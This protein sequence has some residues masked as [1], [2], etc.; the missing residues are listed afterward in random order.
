[1][2]SALSKFENGW[3]AAHPDYFFVVTSIEAVDADG[4]PD[5]QIGVFSDVDANGQPTTAIQT[6]PEHTVANSQGLIY[7]T[8]VATDHNQVLRVMFRLVSSTATKQCTLLIERYTACL[9]I[10]ALKDNKG[11]TVFSPPV[12]S[13][14]IHYDR[15]SQRFQL[16]V[17]GAYVRDQ[18]TYLID[19]DDF[20]PLHDS[21]RFQGACANRDGLPN[22][23]TLPWRE[24]WYSAPTATFPHAL[25]GSFPAY[26]VR[27]N[28]LVD[29][30][31][32]QCD[33]VHFN[34]TYSFTDFTHCPTRHT[35][36]YAVAVTNENGQIFYRGKV[37]VNVLVPIDLTQEQWGYSK[38]R[39][40]YP[41][42]FGFKQRISAL[43]G[44]PTQ[45]DLRVF[46][47]SASTDPV[48]GIMTLVVET[49]YARLE[50]LKNPSVSPAGEIVL[51][52]GSDP[53][54]GT[55]SVVLCIQEWTY[56]SPASWTDANNHDYQFSWQAVYDSH[57]MGVRITIQQKLEEIQSETG[58]MIGDLQLRIFH[59]RSDLILGQN[60]DN[61]LDYT[62]QPRDTVYV[63]ADLV[64]PTDDQS[65]FNV[66]VA[67]AYL[68]Y[69]TIEGYQIEYAPD[70]KQGC[71]DPFIQA[72]ERFHL[73]SEKAL[74]TDANVAD[75]SADLL[76]DLTT[77]LNPNG[78]SDAFSFLANPQQ[79]VDRIYTIHVELEVNQ[80]P[81]SA[82]N[83]DGS[84]SDG[85]AGSRIHYVSSVPTPQYA[86][87]VEFSVQSHQ[88]R[89]ADDTPAGVA[90][91]SV[92]SQAQ[93]VE[94]GSFSIWTIIL[95]A[96]LCLAVA[97][98]A[99][100]AFLIYRRKYATYSLV[101]TVSEVDI[102][103]SQ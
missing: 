71:L 45:Q 24:M 96:G 13:A 84:V 11:N 58:L 29:N 52:S 67:N 61:N 6:P 83:V 70:G 46:I 19:F 87:D 78:P 86:R 41:F 53:C 69:T 98:V 94:S 37:Y 26:K 49:Q 80:R 95:G 16:N 90:A 3:N 28:W 91:I 66:I 36:N 5:T 18:G 42:E 14:R 20:D 10:P 57:Q 65:N 102:E 47:R 56:Q 4:N 59:T 7:W 43:V 35:S 2:D 27:N 79:Q 48:T 55:Q 9:G 72:S 89:A 60:D 17:A 85:L 74:G 54:P 1:L 82:R 92:K 77:Y 33:K 8:P 99:A 39:H 62:F 40:V 51:S 22:A 63:R 73:I 30:L 100:S 34:T 88:L 101:A 81:V 76:A 93:P 97:G 103:G 68:C 12:P 21:I 38:F 50:G 31:N 23:Q 25:D 15:P 32:S 44:T 64:V 75:F